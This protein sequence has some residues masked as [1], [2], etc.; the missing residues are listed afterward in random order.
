MITLNL[1]KTKQLVFYTFAF[2]CIIACKAE[3]KQ[4]IVP[5]INSTIEK[6][7]IKS[8]D[9]KPVSEK[10]HLNRQELEDTFPF[11]IG[12]LERDF[13]QVSG[14]MAT[15]EGAF[16]NGKIHLKIADAAGPLGNSLI[17]MFNALFELIEENPPTIQVENKLR[18]GIKTINRYETDTQNASIE[19][20][21][22]NRF[23]MLLTGKK[24][25]P[26]ELWSLFDFDNYISSLQVLDDFDNKN[27]DR[28]H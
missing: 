10:I 28:N 21:Y 27:I 7:L 17:T 9:Q 1:H 14:D 23:H 20:I 4:T 12:D 2:I 15:T 16:G 8:S 3:T 6:A 26:D 24:L 18:N 25:T 11:R 5:E 13:L 19:F 22:I